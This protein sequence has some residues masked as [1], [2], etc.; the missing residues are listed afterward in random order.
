MS[1]KGQL[2]GRVAIVTGASR[3]VGAEL[4]R[5][6]AREGA[7][8]VVNYFRS[9]DAAAAVVNEIKAAGGSAVAHYGDVTVPADMEALAA[10]AVDAFGR[11]DVLVNNALV[12]Y[13]FDPTSAQASIKTVEWDHFND[14]FKGTVGGAVNAVRAVLPHMEQRNYGKIINVGTNL[15]YDPVV[16]Y[17]DYNT[18]K[19]ALVG[20]TRNLAKELGPQGIRVNLVAGGLLEKTDAS[21]LTT[22]EVF[23]FVAG[24]T[25]LRKTTTVT[26]FAEACV[27]FAASASDAVTGQSLSI[28]GGLTMP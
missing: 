11:I 21:S 5:V 1:T 28:D 9:S 16:T 19:A 4:A 18:T 23:G 2:D 26:D 20:L 25:P 13:K 6:Y 7:S 15:V 14:Q 10:A 8:V 27:Y 24:V 17:Y 22:P 3:G 12:N